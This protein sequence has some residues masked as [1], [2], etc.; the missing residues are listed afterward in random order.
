MTDDAAK[1]ANG[2]PKKPAQVPP[3]GTPA[4]TEGLRPTPV[5]RPPEN[6]AKTPAPRVDAVEP[7][8]ALTR[9]EATDGP[10]S[11][12]HLHVRHPVSRGLAVL[13]ALVC[14]LALVGAGYLYWLS[15][16]A[17]VNLANRLDALDGR[18]A[19]VE[20]RDGAAP[21]S[22]QPLDQRIAALEKRTPPD[23]APLDQRLG[24]LEK[25]TP[26]APEDL[27]PLDTRVAALEQRPPVDIAPLGA[28]IDALE[29]RPPVDLA[30]LGARIDTL[31]KR[32]PVDLGPLDQRLT[33]LENKPPVPSP[34]DTA[35]QAVVA[36]LAARVDQLTAREDQLGTREQADTAKLTEE[37]QAQAGRLAAQDGKIAGAVAA[38]SKA[39]GDVEALTAKGA[40]MAAL[41]AGAVALADGRP[42]GNIP[43]APPALAQFATKP[44]P[45]EASL[46]L[47]FADVAR[48]AHDAG[49]PPEQDAPFLSRAWAR[50]Q[51]TVTVRQG[52]RVI[53]GDPISGVLAHSQSQLDAGDLPGAVA[54]LDQL[55]GPA[56][57]AMGPWKQQAQSLLDARAA[58]L[59]M[60]HG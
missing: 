19:A 49:L 45:T 35:G 6:V 54:T 9:A 58:L 32:P 40:R 52:D 13:L 8:P 22:L 53:V 27:G 29:K 59:T 42:V 47:S 17:A 21:V 2:A 44:P 14:V 30:P 24:A 51:R 39:G 33:T 26:P 3:S 50:M 48:E 20:T 16:I 23:L 55:A 31:E 34:L 46:R 57:A 43:G 25:R 60:A 4:P 37:L 7:D 5:V 12:S 36:T 56:A 15:R 28:R 38:G 18:V 41:Q 1:P 10:A 11:P